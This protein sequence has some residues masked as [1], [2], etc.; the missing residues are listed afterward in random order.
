MFG[1]VDVS[2]KFALDLSK[3]KKTKTA[4]LWKQA[5]KVKY[6]YGYGVMSLQC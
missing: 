2:H 3:K 6:A 5:K 1:L 4:I